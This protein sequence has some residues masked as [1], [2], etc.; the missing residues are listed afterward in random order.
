MSKGQETVR[1]VGVDLGQQC[2]YTAIS[3]T[4]RVPVPTGE[5]ATE[6]YWDH[7]RGG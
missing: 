1:L 2:D 7:R 5:A 6:E 4:E 3:V